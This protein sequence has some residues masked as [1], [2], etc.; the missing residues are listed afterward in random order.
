VNIEFETGEE[1]FLIECYS[2]TVGLQQ[3]EHYDV[4]VGA[5]NLLV[6]LVGH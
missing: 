3:L 4:V 1:L 2:L 5:G 6:T